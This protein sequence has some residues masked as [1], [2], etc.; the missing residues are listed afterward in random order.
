MDVF[1]R[2]RLPEITFSATITGWSSVRPSCP[3]SLF[4]L[5]GIAFPVRRLP[6]RSRFLLALGSGCGQMARSQQ[7]V[8]RYAKS[9][10]SGLVESVPRP[11]S[12]PA[13]RNRL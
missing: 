4:A 6:C 5:F 11:G 1:V 13:D 2:F 10:V 3:A 9:G 8:G 12:Q 7:P